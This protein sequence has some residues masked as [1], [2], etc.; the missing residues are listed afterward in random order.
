MRVHKFVGLLLAST[1]VSAQVYAAP[2]PNFDLPDLVEKVLPSVVNVS[3]TAIRS[4]QVYGMDEFLNL[5][6]VPQERKEKQTS[7][8]SGF[9]INKDGYILTNNHVVEHA[10]EVMIT[11]LDKR[12]FRAKII[13]TDEK[14]DL[15][16][17]QVRDKKFSVPDNLLP[18]NLGDSE[19]LRIA[20]SVFAVGN[21]FGLQHTVTLGIISAKHRTIGSGPFDN[22]IQTDAS[23][24]PGNSG[25]PLFNMKGEVIGINTMIYS[26]VG[27]SGGVGFAIPINEAKRLIPD[28]QKYGRVPRPWL[29]IMGD[30]MTPQIEAYFGLHTS[31]GVLVSN[32]I[33]DGPADVAGLKQGDVIIK[34]DGAAMKE[35]Y[36][37][38]RVLA[39][40]KP[41]DSVALEVQRGRKQVEI[42]VKT[43]EL[44]HL[45][46]LP[47]G[48]I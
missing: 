31:E 5:W 17:L 42:S 11:L 14:M 13:G 34:M 48:I 9:I 45:D 21:P 46:K 36:D 22:Y 1:L 7:L 10:N 18:A 24:N 3:S 30:R 37:I 41:N 26:R 25:G 12:Q 44:P 29:G 6:G 43:Q 27:Q 8:G 4:Y 35:P 23:I 40:H 32:L 20:E 2:P 33:Q 28:L 47:Q 39:K 38:E 15:A 16:L 19:T